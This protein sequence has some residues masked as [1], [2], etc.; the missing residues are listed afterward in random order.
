MFELEKI[1]SI[2][3][4]IVNVRYCKFVSYKTVLYILPR[5]KLWR[6]IFHPYY[7]IIII[8]TMYKNKIRNFFFFFVLDAFI[9]A[10]YY[11]VSRKFSSDRAEINWSN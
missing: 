6:N 7:Q 3:R 5:R 8:P 10:I 1:Q 11:S 2:E 9:F 4:N